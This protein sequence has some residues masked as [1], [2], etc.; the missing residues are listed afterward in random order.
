M[1][2]PR[3]SVMVTGAQKGI[4][5]GIALAFGRAGYAV[6]VNYLDDR[7]AAQ[8]VVD[9]IVAVGGAA[10]LS[11]FDVSDLAAVENAMAGTAENFGGLDVLVNNAAIFPRSDFLE[12]SPAE[13]DAVLSVNLRGTAF[14][15]QFAARIMAKQGGGCII[16]TSSQAVRGVSRSAHY[17]ASKGA[18]VSLTRAL[19]VELAPL[20]IRVNAISPGLIDTDQPRVVHTDEELAERGRAVPW[21]RIGQPDDIAGTA[22]FLASGAADYITGQTI[23]VNGGSYLP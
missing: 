12:M 19:A 1:S 10:M 4:G 18:I 9:G 3:K 17:V 11:Q 23:H 6:A 5:A 20:R 16:N 15:A 13:W 22:L 21:G 8:S 2:A 7:D 14:A